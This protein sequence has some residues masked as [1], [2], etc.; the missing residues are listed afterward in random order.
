MRLHPATRLLTLL[1]AV[2]L[3]G[4]LAV[5]ADGKRKRPRRYTAA[6]MILLDWTICPSGATLTVAAGPEGASDSPPGPDPDARSA[7]IDA[8]LPASPPGTGSIIQGGPNPNGYEL[9]DVPDYAVLPGWIVPLFEGTDEVVEEEAGDPIDPIVPL[10]PDGNAP[11]EV[12]W[13]THQ[14]GS[15]FGHPAPSEGSPPVELRWSSPVRVGKPGV[16]LTLGGDTYGLFEVVS[17]PEGGAPD[18]NSPGVTTPG[19]SLTTEEIRDLPD[20]IDE[21][22]QVGRGPVGS[23]VPRSQCTIVGTPGDDRIEGTPGNDV[24]CGLGGKDVIDGDRGIDLIDGANGND[25]LRG[26]PG[27]DLHLL[28]LRGDDRLDG[29][30]GNDRA[31]GGAGSDRVRGSSGNDPLL[32]GGWGADRLRGGQGRDRIRGG[33]GRDRIRARDRTRDRVDGGSGW[34]RA[35]VD[36]LGS[37]ARVPRR[38]DRVR[39]VE[40]LL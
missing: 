30:S 5:P 32:S 29:N 21:N 35:R 7:G 4:A 27:N 39:R 28:G 36:R 37:K 31:S 6:D 34:D 13:I 1:M 18:D 15:Y 19:P 8:E 26:G 23:L 10:N 3:V 2:L 16:R 38:A 22:R 12:N 24:I 14:A 9:K 33:L 17:C 40:R 25:T 20:Q 11:F